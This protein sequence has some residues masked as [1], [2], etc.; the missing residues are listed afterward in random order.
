MARIVRGRLEHTPICQCGIRVH[1]T[2]AV[3]F[4]FLFLRVLMATVGVADLVPFGKEI[5]SAKAKRKHTTLINGN[6]LN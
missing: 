6:R 5:Y 2:A 4:H 1:R 3:D